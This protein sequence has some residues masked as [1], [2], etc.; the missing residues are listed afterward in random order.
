[1]WENVTT[2]I[3]VRHIQLHHQP[4]TLLAGSFGFSKTVSPPVRSRLNMEGAAEPICSWKRKPGK[5]ISEVAH[6]I[7]SVKLVLL[8]FIHTHL[9][10][11]FIHPPTSQTLQHSAPILSTVQLTA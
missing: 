10:K 6:Q 3:Q 7:Q 9:I 2:I 11:H 1:M 4:K 5:A 8:K